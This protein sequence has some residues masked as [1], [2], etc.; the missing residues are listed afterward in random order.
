VNGWTGTTLQV[1]LTKTKAVPETYDSSLALNF[2]GGRGFAA[3]I[4]WDKLAVGT[5]SLSP[6]ILLIFAAG[7]L[8][9]VGLP[10]SG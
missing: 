7:P 4:L 10:N 3:K 5:E 6:D 9:G 1:N 8:T 2:L